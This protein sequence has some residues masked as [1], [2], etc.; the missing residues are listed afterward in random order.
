VPTL[1]SDAVELVPEAACLDLDSAALTE[2]QRGKPRRRL[3]YVAPGTDPDC[4]AGA[5]E[6]QL[7]EFAPD[8]FEDGFES[9]N[10]LFWSHATD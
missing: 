10:T 8:I 4:D 3:P 2:D 1:S 5:A 7:A 6:R 9:G